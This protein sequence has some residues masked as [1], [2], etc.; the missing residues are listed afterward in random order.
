MMLS[1]ES[2]SFDPWRIR[3]VN[4]FTFDT[5][6]LQ[7]PVQWWIQIKIESNNFTNLM[8]I[9]LSIHVSL[10]FCYIYMASW[11]NQLQFNDKK[12]KKRVGWETRTTQFFFLHL[13]TRVN[14]RYHLSENFL[15]KWTFDPWDWILIRMS[16]NLLP[17]F[18]QELLLVV[19]WCVLVGF[20]FMGITSKLGK[21]HTKQTYPHYKHNPFLVYS[22]Y[23]VRCC[24]PLCH[25]FKKYRLPIYITNQAYSLWN[26]HNHFK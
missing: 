15:K 2:K 11:Q 26:V 21:K 13:L 3:S 5:V 14:V 6:P 16:I 19:Y 22:D 10:H 7:L 8:L 1:N 12:K 18:Y 25:W 9:T 24:H 17:F 23:L 4:E 20:F